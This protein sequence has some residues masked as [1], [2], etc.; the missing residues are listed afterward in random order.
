MAE[1]SYADINNDRVYPTLTRAEAGKIA[2][3][4]V[5]VFGRSS[6]AAPRWYGNARRGELS[7]KLRWWTSNHRSGARRV[8]VATEPTRGHRRGWGRLIHDV[9]HMVHEYRNPKF[10]PHDHLHA[11]VERE[12]QV[13]VEVTW[14]SK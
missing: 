4:L 10:K 2:K 12:V 13:H 9:S 14:L 11:Q 5:K 1:A 8:W 7:K 6:D 3:E